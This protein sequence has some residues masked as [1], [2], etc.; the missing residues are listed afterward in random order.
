MSQ[1]KSFGSKN[2]LCSI[3]IGWIAFTGPDRQVAIVIC[4]VCG[5]FMKC[6]PLGI[7]FH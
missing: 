1:V 4:T 5:V 2:R 6:D 7:D 3:A